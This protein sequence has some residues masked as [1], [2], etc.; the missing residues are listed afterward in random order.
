MIQTYDSVED[1]LASGMDNPGKPIYAGRCT[2]SPT[3]RAIIA[4]STS[5]DWSKA[6]KAPCPKCGKEGW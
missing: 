2:A 4:A 1:Y 3:C 6:V 5:A